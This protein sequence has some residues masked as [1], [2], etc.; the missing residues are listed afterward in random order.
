MSILYAMLKLYV[1]GLLFWVFLL[2]RFLLRNAAH[3]I[4]FIGGR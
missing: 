3:L 2:N 1:F 4:Q